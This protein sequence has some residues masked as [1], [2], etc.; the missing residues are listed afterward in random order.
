MTGE[1]GDRWFALNF[2][3]K[4]RPQCGATISSTDAIASLMRTHPLEPET[5]ERIEIVMAHE[6][7]C[8]LVGAGFAVGENPQVSGQFNVR[9]CVANA[10]V[11][12]SSRLEHFT[13]EAVTAPTVGALAERTETRVDPVLMEGTFGKASRAQVCR[14]PQTAWVMETPPPG[15]PEHV[16]TN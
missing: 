11:R 10:I 13:N 2:G 12:K 1:L 8:T 4:T 9:Y 5:I 14:H 16:R 7:P 6:G 3:Y 15:N